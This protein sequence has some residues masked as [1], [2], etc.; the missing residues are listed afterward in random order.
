MPCYR[1]KER[2]RQANN[3]YCKEC[4]N[5]IYAKWRNA[6]KAKYNAYHRKYNN[7][8]RRAKKNAVKSIQPETKATTAS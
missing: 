5:E 8:L 1:C 3:T 2:P 6:N 7:E 4:R